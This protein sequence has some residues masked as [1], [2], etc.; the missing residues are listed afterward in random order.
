M[1]PKFSEFSYGYSVTRELELLAKLALGGVSAPP[2]LPSLKAE[3]DLGFDVGV[4]TVRLAIFVQFKLGEYVSRAAPGS[5]TWPYLGK[6]HYRVR[7]DTSDHQF[8][9]LLDLEKRGVHKGRPLLVMYTAPAF[10]TR[11]T[12]WMHY[13][14]DEVLQHSYG[15]APSDLPCDGQEHHRV[16][17]ADHSMNGVLSE[18]REVQDRLERQTLDAEFRQLAEYRGTEFSLVSLEQ[19]LRAAC[20]SAGIAQ[21]GQLDA[22]DAPDRGVWDQIQVWSQMLEVVP[23]IWYEGATA[24]PGSSDRG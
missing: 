9:A 15:F 17:T 6:E 4:L 1:R 20:A 23:L 21:L 14:A 24:D 18:L 13:S 19:Q 2:M 7:I 16:V 8:L 3:K 22:L 11:E 12:F 10:W 5:P